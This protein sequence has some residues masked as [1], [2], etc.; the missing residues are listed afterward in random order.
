MDAKTKKY[1]AFLC[2]TLKIPQPKLTTDDTLFEGKTLLSMTC[3]EDNEIFLR[4]QYKLE[5]DLYFALA[6]E[7]RHLWQYRQGKLTDRLRNKPTSAEGIREYNLLWEE[8]DANA[9]AVVCMEDLFRIRPLFNGLDE[10]VKE[11]IYK[12]AKEFK[13]EED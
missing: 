10:D 2:K 7:I 13:L 8:L 12:M 11:Q 5:T 6:H 4:S 3:V 1:V 9:F